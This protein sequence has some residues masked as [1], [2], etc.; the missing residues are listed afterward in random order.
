[1]SAHPRRKERLN[2]D[3]L[4]LKVR[5]RLFVNIIAQRCGPATPV[6]KESQRRWY[7]KRLIAMSSLF[8]YLS[9]VASEFHLQRHI[10]I[11]VPE[12]TVFLILPGLTLQRYTV[13]RKLLTTGH[14]N[15]SVP[16]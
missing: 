2:P 4:L 11:V 16:Q 10:I 14:R 15:R 6:K 7:R 13:I 12:E 5:G 8:R 1:M 3:R 9:R